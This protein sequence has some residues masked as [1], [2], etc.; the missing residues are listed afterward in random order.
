M[1]IV[2]GENDGPVPKAAEGSEHRLQQSSFLLKQRAIL[3]VRVRLG[4]CDML[5]RLI[6]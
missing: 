5:T 1:P 3:G 2:D 4:H 6:Q